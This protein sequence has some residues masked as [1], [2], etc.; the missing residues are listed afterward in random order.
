MCHA[1]QCVFKHGEPRAVKGNVTKGGII[2]HENA[3]G[4]I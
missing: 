2:S 4:Q 3:Y 1:V